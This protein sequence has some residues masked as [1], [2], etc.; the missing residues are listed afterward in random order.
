MW[1]RWVIYAARVEDGLKTTRLQDGS[2][3]SARAR[4]G[5]KIEELPQVG[6]C[7]WEVQFGP[8]G[9][10]Q[11]RGSFAATVQH[12]FRLT[13]GCRQAQEVADYLE[14]AKGRTLLYM[15]FVRNAGMGKQGRAKLLSVKRE[16]RTPRTVGFEV[17]LA[18]REEDI[19][20]C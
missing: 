19:G 6:G 15:V 3:M 1:H 9:R 11:E 8:E 12:Q 18:L 17:T 5:M 7:S 14:Q 4:V 16:E 2:A 20:W 13:V 10:V